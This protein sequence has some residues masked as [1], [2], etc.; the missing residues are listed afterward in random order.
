MSTNADVVGQVADIV[1][2]GD[3]VFGEAA[4]HRIAGVLLLLAQRLPA[5]QAVPAVAAGGVEP[6]HADPVAFLD[7]RARRRRRR[8]RGPRPHG[9]G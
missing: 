2:I 7:V 4:V 3:D 1:R 5:A 9:P 6:G 8:R